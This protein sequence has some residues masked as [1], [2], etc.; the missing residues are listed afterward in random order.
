MLRD[1]WDMSKPFGPTLTDYV[2]VFPNLS[3]VHID[4]VFPSDQVV[5][6]N[7]PS[8][9]EGTSPFKDSTIVEDPHRLTSVSLSI[10]K[11]IDYEYSLSHIWYIVRVFPKIAANLKQF[12]IDELDAFY[13]DFLADPIQNQSI[14][15]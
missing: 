10:T 4:L 15:R 2:R 13:L 9:P 1:G 14:P 12:G 11:D 5:T 3:S 8:T 6:V 7:S